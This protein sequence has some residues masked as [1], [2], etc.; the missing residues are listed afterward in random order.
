MELERIALCLKALGDPKRLQLLT[1][2]QGGT[3]CNCQFS[4]LLDLQ[5][6]LISH[7]LRILKEAGLV[8]I[9]RDPL[10]SRWIYYTINQ[11]VYSEL[12][13]YLNGFFDPSR[14]QPRQPTC[15]PINEMMA[16]SGKII[17]K[18]K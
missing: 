17:T 18:A 8:T 1:L 16:V 11:A 4:D 15:G 3:Q 10:D 9:E 5:P 13:E 7:H 6:N 14:I 2:I 12:R